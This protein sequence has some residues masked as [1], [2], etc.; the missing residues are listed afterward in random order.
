MSILMFL[1]KIPALIALPVMA[2]LIAL[3]G[4]VH[5]EDIL[6]YVI[7]GGSLKLYNAYTI[8]MMGSMLS[9]MLQKTGVAESLIKKGAELSGDNPWIIAVL[10][11][12]L[13]IMLFSILGGLGAIIMVA[14]I[15]LPIMSSV[16]IG[17]VTAVGI[18][19]FGLSIGGI[20]NVG[21]WAVY[22]SVMGLKFW[23]I[24]QFAMVIF[25]ISF[26]TALIYITV[27]LYRDGQNLNIRRIAF[28]CLAALSAISVVCCIFI[29]A[30]PQTIRYEI[31]NFI[32]A[33]GI[34]LKWAIASG[35]A[36]LYLW[37][38]IRIY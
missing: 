14:T 38:V 16:G 32:I 1:R 15:V 9:V 24:E 2:I 5:A 18:F 27:Q 33:C 17:S 4:G 20:L 37:S 34:F 23:E 11:L 19:L 12:I 21:N 10:T 28:S 6:E 35:I 3:F 25:V 13:I 8:A 22:I 26:I 31:W 7:G 29:Y 36:A 30:V